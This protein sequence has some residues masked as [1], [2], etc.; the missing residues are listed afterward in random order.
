MVLIFVQTSEMIKFAVTPPPERWAA[1]DSGLKLLNW[2]Q[3]RYMAEYGLKIDSQATVVRGRVLQNPKVTFGAGGAVDPRTSG[4]WDL[5]GKKFLDP[6]PSPLKSWGVCIIKGRGAASEEQVRNFIKTFVGVFQ[7]HGGK[8]A[9]PTPHIM[10]P[11]SMDRAVEE[12]Y[13]QTGDKFQLKP[14]LLVFIVPDKDSQVYARLKKSS[15]CRYGVVSQVLQSMYVQKAQA[16]YCSNV[17][18]KVNAK[19]GGSTSRAVGMKG[20]T[21]WFTKPT[22]VIGA[23]VSHS[24]P[25]VVGASIAAVTVSW[26]RHAI[27]YA[28]IVETNGA[29]VEMI[30]SETMQT[31][32]QPLI[33]KWV[34]TIAGGKT[35]QH[36]LYFRDGVSEGQY[37]QV[38]QTE[39]HDLRKIIKDMNPQADVKFTVIVASKRHHVRFFPPVGASNNDFDRNGNALP[40]T[41]V[42]SGV[43]HPFEYDFYLCA[44]N[45]LKGTARPVHYHV[46]LDEAKMSV[47]EL[48]NMVYEASYQYVRSTTPVS[49][50]PAVY[51]AHLASNR[52]THHIDQASISS[53]EKTTKKTGSSAP[54]PSDFK[55]L[56]EMP[57][58]NGIQETMWYV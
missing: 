3:D 37:A 24:A 21:G 2:P 19:L 43:T 55:P 31:R 14:Q 27:K 46:L 25:G 4:R 33:K 6:H 23:D 48:Q 58:S 52:G 29:R 34:S 54:E 47:E 57:N 11:S 53:Q 30:R 38:L 39:V 35:P 5:K 32:V 16:Q 17:C 13:R 50:F 20:S 12:V 45:A 44:H 18:M 10:L 8:V 1:V 49:L 51:Y 28:A 42:E 36:V 56:L 26:D 7:A 9:T 22:M 41:L 15:D 40:G